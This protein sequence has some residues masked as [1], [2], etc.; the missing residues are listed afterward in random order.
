MDTNS[1]MVT[2][3][4]KPLLNGIIVGRCGG[5]IVGPMLNWLRIRDIWLGSW[6]R[7][8]WPVKRARRLHHVGLCK[9]LL[10]L[11][12]KSRYPGTKP[13]E[14][15]LQAWGLCCS[16]WRGKIKRIMCRRSRR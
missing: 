7:S 15:W 4:W 11:G 2:I 9:I 8:L 10:Q 16:G 1:G 13:R 14:R 5:S 12:L 6:G 3:T